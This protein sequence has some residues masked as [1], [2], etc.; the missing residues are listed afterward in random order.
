MAQKPNTNK[1][2]GAKAQPIVHAPKPSQAS[3]S[4]AGQQ[5]PKGPQ[6]IPVPPAKQPLPPPP[7][8][9]P[10]P[11]DPSIVF[12]DPDHPLY[13]IFIVEKIISC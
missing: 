7:S 8:P 9:H 3:K 11:D 5:S 4:G 1:Q 6:Q 13:V 2:S 10:Q 12:F